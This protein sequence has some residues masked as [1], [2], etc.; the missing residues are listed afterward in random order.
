MSDK[1]CQRCGSVGGYGCYECIPEDD[2]RPA[3]TPL[4]PWQVVLSA[5]VV[6][7]LLSV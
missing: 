4:R 6:L 5:V 1:E 3:G 2:F 7:L